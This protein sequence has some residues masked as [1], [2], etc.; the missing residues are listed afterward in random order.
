MPP[1]LLDKALSFVLQHRRKIIYGLAVLAQVL[2][3]V[4]G[5]RAPTRRTTKKKR[6]TPA[7]NSR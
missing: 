4:P 1:P 3:T 2:D 5:R 6:L 7:K